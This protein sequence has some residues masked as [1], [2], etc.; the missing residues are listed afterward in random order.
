MKDD[1]VKKYLMNDDLIMK[2]AERLYERMDVEKHMRILSGKNWDILMLVDFNTQQ[3]MYIRSITEFVT[4]SNFE[5][6]THCK[7]TCKLQSH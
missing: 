7:E 4:P 3:G 5:T 1:A 6:L 2:F